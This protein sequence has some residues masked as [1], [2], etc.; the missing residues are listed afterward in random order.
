MTD[1]A[2]QAAQ[3][4]QQQPGTPQQPVMMMM[5]PTSVAVGETPDKQNVVIQLNT[6][7][8]SIAI[9]LT[10]NDALNHCRI[11]RTKAKELNQNVVKRQGPGGAVLLDKAPV[12][13]EGDGEDDEDDEPSEG[14][15]PSAAA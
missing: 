15:T 6:I 1:I 9:A 12:L 11:L 7:Y 3:A 8:G 5:P 14:E 10:P 13:V 4:A 2:Q